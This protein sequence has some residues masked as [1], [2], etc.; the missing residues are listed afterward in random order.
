VSEQRRVR[1]VARGEVQGVS[2]RW[3]A[4]EQAARLGLLGWVRNRES[5][6]VEGVA[7]GPDE[8]LEAFLTWCRRGPPAARVS[9]VEVKEEPPGEALQPFSIRR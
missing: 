4:R 1:F 5:G 9:G 3:S 7:E 6:E 2:Y 8:A